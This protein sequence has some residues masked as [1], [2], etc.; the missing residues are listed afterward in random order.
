MNR[1]LFQQ[2][3]GDKGLLFPTLNSVAFEPAQDAVCFGEWKIWSRGYS[4]RTE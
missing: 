4:R 2:D 3:L 1:V